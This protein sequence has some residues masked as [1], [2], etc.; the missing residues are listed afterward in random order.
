MAHSYEFVRPPEYWDKK[1][2]EEIARLTRISE[3]Q[4]KMLAEAL[5]EKNKL[6][7]R[8]YEYLMDQNKSLQLDLSVAQKQLREIKENVWLLFRALGL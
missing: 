4:S 7:G 2:K 3:R 8:Q 1:Q 5:Y 6:D